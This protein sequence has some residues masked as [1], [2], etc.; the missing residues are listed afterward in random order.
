MML[1]C[2]SLS[3]APPVASST[4][5]IAWPLQASPWN[6]T[7]QPAISVPMGLGGNGLPL[8]VQ[9]IGPHWGEGAILRAA[10]VLERDG[11]RADVPLPL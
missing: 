3:T 9:L 1:G 11:G 10:R 4:R 2:I 7:G 5:P 8:A 6:V